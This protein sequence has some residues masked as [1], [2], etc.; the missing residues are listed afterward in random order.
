MAYVDNNE[1]HKAKP[2]FQKYLNLYCANPIFRHDNMSGCIALT[3]LTYEKNL[4][5]EQKIELINTVRNNLPHNSAAHLPAV[6]VLQF[7]IQ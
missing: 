1:Y 7:P 4:T 2:F 5:R 3:T 6:P